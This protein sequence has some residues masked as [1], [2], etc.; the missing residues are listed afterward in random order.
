MITTPA[1]LL[2]R[3]IMKKMH[4]CGGKPDLFMFVPSEFIDKSIPPDYR[5]LN[6]NLKIYIEMR[7]GECGS[8][9]ET[10]Y[11]RAMFFVDV[12]GVTDHTN[13]FRESF[14][15][16][17]TGSRDEYHAYI[18]LS[19]SLSQVHDFIKEFLFYSHFGDVSLRTISRRES[20]SISTSSMMSPPDKV[21]FWRWVELA[22][23]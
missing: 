7:Q 15:Y 19:I 22:N 20:S 18:N 21:I 5:T 2:C 16:D 13:M 11:H 17:K 4:F 23:K 9:L 1:K 12:K 8:C 10:V 3:A 6:E 14:F